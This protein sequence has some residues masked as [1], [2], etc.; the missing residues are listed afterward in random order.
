MFR[1]KRLSSL[2]AVFLLVTLPAWADRYP[3]DNYDEPTVDATAPAA[4][5]MLE[6]E[7]VMESKEPEQV[8]AIY[9]LL[10]AKELA[11]KA[12]FT[13]KKEESGKYSFFNEQ[14]GPYMIWR[15][16]TLACQLSRYHS[17][18]ADR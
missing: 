6:L 3:I 8:D 12:Q 11:S 5:W 1:I 14:T 2:F 10:T 7:F 13:C 9:T 17:G 4:E 16:V 18:L 15:A